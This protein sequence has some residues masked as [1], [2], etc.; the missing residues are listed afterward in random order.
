MCNYNPEAHSVGFIV[1]LLYCSLR[2]CSVQYFPGSQNFKYI[3]TSDSFIRSQLILVAPY[4]IRQ[5]CRYCPYSNKPV[6]WA[7]VY[8]VVIIIC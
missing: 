4:V 1:W 3:T 2:Q 5:F 7:T 8:S 6:I